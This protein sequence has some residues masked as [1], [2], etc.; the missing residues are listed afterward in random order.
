MKLVERIDFNSL[1]VRTLETNLMWNLFESHVNMCG[2]Q[3]ASTQD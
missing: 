2:V 3:T 1:L